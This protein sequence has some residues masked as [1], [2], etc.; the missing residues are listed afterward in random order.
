MLA[1]LPL[2]VASTALSYTR[3]SLLPYSSLLTPPPP[4]LWTNDNCWQYLKK[5][6]IFWSSNWEQMR[7]DKYIPIYNTNTIWRQPSLILA[8]ILPL[9]SSSPPPL[10]QRDYC[11]QDLKK[12]FIIWSSNWEQMRIDKLYKNITFTCAW[13]MPRKLV[14]INISKFRSITNLTPTAEKEERPT[15]YQYNSNYKTYAIQLQQPS[16]SFIILISLSSLDQRQLLTREIII[17]TCSEI[18]NKR[19]T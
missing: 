8:L 4:L 7:I 9:N 2:P 18:E 15:L 11:W 5:E 19:C 12:E 17:W 13:R 14:P 3:T 10:D 16:F 6:I 1:R